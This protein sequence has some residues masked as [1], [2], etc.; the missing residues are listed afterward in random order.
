[1]APD[2]KVKHSGS[3]A[4]SS[5]AIPAAA[6]VR[7]LSTPVKAAVDADVDPGNSQLASGLDLHLHDDRD[8]G[9]EAA[10]HRDAEA[11]AVRRA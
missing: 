1:M 10:M 7:A 3:S 11:L 9:T 4:L 5:L 2:V 6:A 8:V